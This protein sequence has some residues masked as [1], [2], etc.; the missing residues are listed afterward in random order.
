VG[1][2]R[3]SAHDANDPPAHAARLTLSVAVGSLL[4]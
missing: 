3:V 1:R 2:V 4:A